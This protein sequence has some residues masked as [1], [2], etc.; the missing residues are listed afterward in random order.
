[1][2]NP[3]EKDPATL[4]EHQDR[5]AKRVREFNRVNQPSDTE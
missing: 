1:M 4:N 5:K 2:L 3:M